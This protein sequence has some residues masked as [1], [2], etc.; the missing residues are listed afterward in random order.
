MVLYKNH[1]ALIAICDLNGNNG[2][3]TIAIDTYNFNLIAAACVRKLSRSYN[4]KC[5]KH[6]LGETSKFLEL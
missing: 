2:I 6:F 5:I 3:V 1:T 4:E